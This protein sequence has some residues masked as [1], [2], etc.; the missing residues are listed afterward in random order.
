MSEKILQGFITQQA[1]AIVGGAL[2]N[3]GVQTNGSFSM[4]AIYCKPTRD[5]PKR[6]DTIQY[7]QV[8]RLKIV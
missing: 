3:G 2:A 6:A 4:A 7:L 8:R 1:E 5:V